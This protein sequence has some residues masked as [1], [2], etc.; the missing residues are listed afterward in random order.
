MLSLISLA[1]SNFIRFL[2]CP[3]LI[4]IGLI[5]L[6]LAIFYAVQDGVARLRRLHQIPCSHCVFFSGDYRLKCAVHPCKALS[7]E[8]INCLDYEASAHRSRRFLIG[9]SSIKTPKSI[10]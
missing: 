8:A 1:V 5:G 10:A 9:Q 6:F 2:W 7:E 4:W 3:T